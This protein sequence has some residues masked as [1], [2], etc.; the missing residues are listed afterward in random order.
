M[1]N[2]GILIAYYY[3]HRALY[4]LYPLFALALEVIHLYILDG[5]SHTLHYIY[6]SSHGCNKAMHPFLSQ[7]YA[8]MGT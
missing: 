2:L 7:L 8:Q 5:I 4:W 3:F 6:S 1:D